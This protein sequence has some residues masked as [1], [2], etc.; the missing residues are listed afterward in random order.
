MPEVVAPQPRRPRR[1]RLAIAACGLSLLGVCV[2]VWYVQS[3][4]RDLA[5]QAAMSKAASMSVALQKFRSLYTSEVV[6]RVRVH[7]ISTTHDYQEQSASIPL[8]A[9]LTILLGEQMSAVQ[10]GGAVRLYSSHPFPGRQPAGPQD[11]FERTALRSLQEDPTRPYYQV[12]DQDGTSVV[13][14]A[15]ADLMRPSCV[16][17]HNA[18]PD[19]PKRDWRAGDVRGALAVTVDVDPFA[20][21]AAAD[22]SGLIALLLTM[23]VVGSGGFILMMTFQQRRADRD[24]EIRARQQRMSEENAELVMALRRADNRQRALDEHAIV[25]MAD[26]DGKIV[27][28]NDKFCE[29]NDYQQEELLGHP[30]RIVNPDA[31]AP[32]LRLIWQTISTGNTWSGEV[33]NQRKDGSPYWAQTTIV[34]YRNETRQIE[35]YVIIQTDVS[36]IRVTEERMRA[37]YAELKEFSDLVVDRELRMIELKQEVNALTTELGRAARYDVEQETDATEDPD[38][39]QSGR[40]DTEQRES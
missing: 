29:I 15:T 9:T 8:P 33:K 24:A 12:V 22:I 26:T 14:Y 36:A 32:E 3:V 34:P 19:S 25:S 17:C 2:I 38:D 4:T 28:A 35:K 20:A 6:E 16:A 37:A 30:H 5:T 40:S 10:H 13:R 23:A 1:L 11:D 18:H 39:R 7:G 21:A 27:Y 31:H